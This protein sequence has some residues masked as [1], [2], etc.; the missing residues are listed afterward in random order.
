LP[1]GSLVAVGRSLEYRGRYPSLP[2]QRRR[3]SPPGGR[4]FIGSLGEHVSVSGDGANEISVVNRT[5]DR[6]HILA[7]VDSV[8]VSGYCCDAVAALCG[9][10]QYLAAGL[11][12]RA[13]QYEA[14][15][16]SPKCGLMRD[17]FGRRQ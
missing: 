6:S 4:A 11:A 3:G 7:L 9:L 8:Y 1:F 15:L 12:C 14:G 17:F 2:V 5:G 16:V 13:E 10:I